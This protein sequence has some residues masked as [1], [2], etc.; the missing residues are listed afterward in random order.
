MR[1]TILAIAPGGD[2][3]CSLGNTG[4]MAPSASTTA[5]PAARAADGGG[6]ELSIVVPVHDEEENVQ[7]LHAALTSVLSHMGKSYEIIIVDDGSH[8]GTYRKL[9]ILAETDPLLK[10]V[11][12]RR[13][14]GQTA[15][16]AAGFDHASGEVVVP[17][18]GDLQNDPKDIPRLLEKLDEGYDV[19]SGWRKSR[20]DPF[21][22]RLPS[23]M[24]NWLI[25]IVTGV[26]LHDYG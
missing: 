15:A 18:D 9:Q 1:R 16:M 20:E 19:V 14:F 3:R 8:D 24:A 17:M 4:P 10:L 25:G 6:I 13:N 5:A 21:I 22:R 26:R 2:P 7:L 23:R 11:R 12:L